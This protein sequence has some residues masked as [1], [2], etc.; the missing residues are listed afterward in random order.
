[1][2]PKHSRVL[3]RPS[4]SMAASTNQ[5]ANTCGKDDKANYNANI[6]EFAHYYHKAHFAFSKCSGASTPP[7]HWRLGDGRGVLPGSPPALWRLGQGVQPYLQP[8]RK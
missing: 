1:M 6:Y 7:T 3:T 5:S 4:I 2:R 8:F